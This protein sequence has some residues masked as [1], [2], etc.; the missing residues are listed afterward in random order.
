MQLIPV[1]LPRPSDHIPKRLACYP[2]IRCAL[3]RGKSRE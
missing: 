1:V 2:N 3:K